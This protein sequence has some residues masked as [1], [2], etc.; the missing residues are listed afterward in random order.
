MNM[1]ITVVAIALCLAV[2]T[3]ITAEESGAFDSAINNAAMRL[4]EANTQGP[5]RDL[6]NKDEAWDIR[7][8]NAD[9]KATGQ[10]PV[11]PAP[12]PG[13]STTPVSGNAPA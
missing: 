8:E 7:E 9:L 12:T 3:A 10:R 13:A 4:A 6:A 1:K 5:W 11:G 2:A